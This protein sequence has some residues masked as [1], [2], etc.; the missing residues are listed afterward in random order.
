MDKDIEEVLDKFKAWQNKYERIC[1]VGIFPLAICLCLW[2][3]Y[4]G[5]D[6]FLNFLFTVTSLISYPMM[7][8]I[9][10][11][12]GWYTY[13]PG[14][15]GFW[16]DVL[17]SPLIYFF[18]LL[19]GVLLMWV[20]LFGWIRG[21]FGHRVTPGSQGGKLFARM[22]NMFFR[23]KLGHIDRVTLCV[24][25]LAFF[26]GILRHLDPKRAELMIKHSVVPGAIN[27]G[28]EKFAKACREELKDG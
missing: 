3:E 8:T 11:L 12:K 28:F 9:F 1:L 13:E 22:M 6:R 18:T 25:A 4:F 21:K 14:G 26:S 15:K 20:E 7:R 5:G 16:L 27:D 10:F 17:V 24:T 2:I 23:A 19:M